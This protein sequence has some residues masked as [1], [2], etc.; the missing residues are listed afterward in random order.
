MQI[1][2]ISTHDSDYP[3]Q[4]R[5]LHSPPKE[6]F[7]L[8]N[9]SL[10]KTP[11]ISIVGSR[12]ISPYG[13]AATEQLASG[14]AERGVTVVSGLAFGVDAIAHRATLSAG[15]NTLAVMPGGLDSVYPASHRAL[16]EQILAQNGLI[17]S[18]YSAG[19]RVFKQ[20]FIARNRIIAGLSKAV[21]ITEATHKSGS[22]HTAQFAINQNI[23]VLAV[24]GNITSPL[25]EGTNQLIQS[26]AHPIVCAQDVLDI[27]GLSNH[28]NPDS[29]PLA[30]NSA[31]EAIIAL[32]QQGVTDASTLQLQSKLAPD[33]FN[34]TLTMLEITGKIIAQGS[35]HWTFYR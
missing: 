31:E 20:N 10:L 17:I 2:K 22:L 1:S 8:G 14:L 15:G 6:L 33:V 35:N 11:M 26:G 7:A 32:I 34:Q 16:A 18:E 4:L 9:T 21:L 5:A 12:K 13:K 29:S 24:P 3:A 19:S 25:S 28:Q 30:A 23:P 27:V